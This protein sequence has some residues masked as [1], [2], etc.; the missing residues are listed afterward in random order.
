MLKILCNRRNESSMRF[1]SH[2]KLGDN[3]EYCR[4]F[5]FE[6]FAFRAMISTRMDYFSQLV[7]HNTSI[8]Q[9]MMRLAFIVMEI[10][11][12]RI[13]KFSIKEH[14][15]GLWQLA[16]KY[17]AHLLVICFNKSSACS[18][19]KSS[20]RYI[21]RWRHWWRI[22]AGPVYFQQNAYLHANNNSNN[23]CNHNK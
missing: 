4:V 6:W 16:G 15:H 5:P 21:E 1:K 12:A 7:N 13:Y 22:V 3:V 10:H 11:Q 20:L 23:Q 19:T 2:V 8:L 9:I 14:H 18:Q 17:F